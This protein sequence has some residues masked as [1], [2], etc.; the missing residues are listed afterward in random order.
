MSVTDNQRLFQ[1][2]SKILL[3]AA[4]STW[5][6]T[7]GWRDIGTVDILNPKIEQ[8][9]IQAYDSRSGRKCLVEEKVI[10]VAESFEV[11]TLNCSLENAAFI[12]GGTTATYSQSATPLTNIDHK[13]WLGTWCA[14]VDGSGNRVYN[15]ASI[16]SVKSSDGNTTYTLTTDYV[17]STDGLKEG[18]IFI[19]STSTIPENTTIHINFT[20]TAITSSK[21]LVY[22]HT[23]QVIRCLGEVV[24]LESG[25]SEVLA[26]DMFR[27][28]I[29]GGD[30]GMSDTDYSKIK[31]EVQVMEDTSN[32]TMPAGRLLYPVGSI[33]DLSKH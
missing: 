24:W 12:V 22:P 5:A 1:G 27:C 20:P 13:C 31:F 9:K 15:V 8:T 26:R 7:G 14:L 2:G 19:P 18:R 21:R 16:E 17:V 25:G 6:Q 23:T 28:T 11:A 33:P 29:S 32:A 10:A 3:A 30:L 4:D